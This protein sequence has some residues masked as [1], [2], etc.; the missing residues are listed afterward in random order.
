MDHSLPIVSPAPAEHCPYPDCRKS[1][2]DN[3]CTGCPYRADK[4]AI[5]VK[6]GD[7]SRRR[8]LSTPA[9]RASYSARRAVRFARR[10][11]GTR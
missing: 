1:G 4:G 6:T 2:S 11:R 9:R 7:C 5:L 10:M 3:D 8:R